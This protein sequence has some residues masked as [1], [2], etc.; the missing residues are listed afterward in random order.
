MKFGN[1]LRELLDEREIT[2]KKLAKDLNIAPSTL[3]NYIRNIREPDF[4]ML[5]TFASYFQVSVDYLLDYKPKGKNPLTHKE[6]QLL[7][8]FQSLNSEQKEIFIEQGKVFIKQNQK[9]KKD[10][11]MK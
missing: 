9:N 3:G 1:V 6:Q 8:V 11:N 5:K 7:Y 10:L 2:Q 4:E